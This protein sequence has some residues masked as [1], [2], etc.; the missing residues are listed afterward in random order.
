MKARRLQEVFLQEYT[1]VLKS[2]QR[3]EQ[4]NMKDMS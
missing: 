3:F 2:G 4:P 1:A